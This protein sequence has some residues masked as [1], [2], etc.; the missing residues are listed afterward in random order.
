MTFATLLPLICLV[1]VPIIIIL[2]LMKPKGTRK[3]VPSVLLWK[4]TE[5]NER[6]TTF[7]KKL[8]KNILMFLEILAL[9]CLTFAA[10]SPMVKRGMKGSN[11][12]SIIVI[13]TS[14]SMQFKDKNGTTRFSQAIQDAKDYVETS[15]GDIS[16]VTCGASNEVLANGS[17][18]KGKL[19]RILSNIQVTDTAGDISKSEGLLESLK[20][21]EIII[22]TDGDGASRL[23]EMSQKMSVDI[24]VYGDVTS[25]V[26]I[27]QMSMK[28]NDAGTY[29]VAIGY[30]T[31]GEGSHKFDISLYDADGS[32][33]EVRTVD[34]EGN[35]GSTVLMM[36]KS[37]KGDYVKAELSGID[38][39][40]L[41]RDNTA[42][43]IKSVS[44]EVQAYMV[45]V[46]N[47]YFEKAYTA[48]TGNTM[49]KITNDADIPAGENVL[50]IYDR[51]DLVT[52]N[53]P[54]IV[55]GYSDKD[56]EKV[57]G[58]IVTVRTGD[59]IG[60]MNDY[61]FGAS[62]L[63]VL[64]CP[65]WAS[66]L[67]VINAGSEDEKVV[68][69]YG[70]NE[71]VRKV[72]LGFDI[73][74]TEYPLMAEFPIFVAEA[75]TY[76]TDDSLVHS[77]YIQ[78]GEGLS[79][80]PS[81]GKDTVFEAVDSND[82]YSLRKAGLNRLT[83]NAVGEKNSS[84][85]EY[86]VVRYPISEGDGTISHESMSYVKE[87]EYGVRLGSLTRI[88][89]IIALILLILDWII[90][91]TRQVRKNKIEIIIR[92]VLVILVLMSIFGVNLFGRKNKTV[93]IFL[94]DM[95]DSNAS[96]LAEEEEYIREEVKKLPR[97][98]S[99]GVVAFGR[100]ATTDQFVTDDVQ[101][102]GVASTPD[103]SA[104]DIEGAVDYAVALVPEDSLGRMVILTDG[105][106]TVG[107]IN[108]TLNKLKDNDI[109]ICAKLY[110][111]ENV[112]DVYLE[113]VDMPEKLEV[114]DAYSI[115][116]T[117]YSSYE[118]DA[119]LKLWDSSELLDEMNVHL[120]RGENT[121]VLNEVAGDEAIEERKVTIEA[122]GDTITENNSMVAAA[123]V[124]APGKVLIISGARED[125]SG[126]DS[127][128]KN[129]NVDATVVSCI[130]APD[131]I[132][133]LLNYK[134]IILDNCHVKDLPQGFI[135]VIETYVKDYGGGVI[136]TGG[137]ESYAPGGYEDTPLE[138]ILPVDME[139]KGLDEAPSLAM[140]M[141]IDC[142][143]SMSSGG[144][145]NGGRSK[146]DVA[147]DAA[148]EAVDNL[149]PK[150]Y[151]GVV[152]FSDT[153]TWRVPLT[154]VDDKE[155]IKEEIEQIGIMGGTVIKPA[156]IDAAEELSDVDAGV[157]HILLL[158]DGEG[159][160]K[161]FS[162][163]VKLINDNYITMSTIAVGSDSDTT[164]LE[165][166]A[167][168]CNGRYYYSDSSSD[169]PKIFTEEIYLSGNTYYKN[170]DFELSVSN[171]K[172][173]SELYKDGIPNVTGYIATTTKNGA[174]EAISTDEDD[175][176][177]SNWQYGLGHTVAWMT[178][179][180]GTWNEGFASNQD[181]VEMWNRMMDY[182]AMESDI[183]Q[184]RV[185]VYKRRGKV[186]LS[187]LAADYSE[188]TSVVGVYTSPSGETQELSLEPGDPGVYTASFEPSEMGVYSI[189]VRRME[190]EDIAASTTSIE[191]IQFSDEYRKDISNTN[192]TSF[193]ETNG[194]MLSDG[195]NLY[196][197]LKAEN[198][199][200]KDITIWVIILSI[201]ILL[202][203]IVVRRFNLGRRIFK[204]FS[205]KDGTPKAVNT[206]QM[207][208]QPLQQQ[209]V[210]EQQIQ[211]QQIQEQ[212]I[213]EQKAQGQK[214]QQQK[215]QQEAESEGMSGLDTKALLQ[216]KK[217][218]NL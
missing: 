88:C 165:E 123:V 26:G 213:Q 33:I 96:S 208:G 179:A 195:D 57:S 166:L 124:N 133:G 85:S 156:V 99:Y 162:D 153:F 69:Y 155:A 31:K 54:G 131:D 66:P 172:L 164:L 209:G 90:Y 154:K 151:V 34:A 92:T 130:N 72:V 191:T 217:N 42:Y 140:V 202:I 127:I 171:N 41:D 201:I 87:A 23:E 190:G 135:D 49:L 198:R 70:E 176:L 3:V 21:E 71:G 139:P 15:G 36:N 29:D 111:T 193:V 173:V 40:G 24:K 174:R 84:K 168:D 200:K 59:L 91:I 121:F 5:K 67:M 169:V 145:Q 117:V 98:Q 102:V 178:T 215:V 211:G 214:V 56:S 62:D 68:A 35:A 32:L 218:R 79:L 14:G 18:D 20:K 48:I 119:K 94:V 60:D 136:C 109:E 177:L 9:I 216:K 182:A 28:Q 163:A 50:A 77:K 206:Q 205:K 122:D 159:E 52:G 47:T 199:K 142:S 112:S 64:E 80:S 43:A 89:L 17:H 78:A 116:V 175:P 103:G 132:S 189:S 101:F 147:V 152:T 108:N 83:A 115:K 186:E 161:D 51:A 196:T 144:D 141:V 194:R 207:Y 6:S 149:G 180:S 53:Y 25:N 38:S 11:K 1:G 105:C 110:E 126:L 157:R 150:D 128:L 44:D 212:Q 63:S 118:V 97:G 45:G 183:G 82:D 16:I 55:E 187:Y 100:N 46:G 76:I 113:M 73:R 185:S 120:I 19:K 160:T 74:N 7:S 204:K 192:F 27:S 143:G 197:R 146:M 210:Q 203:D 134:T 167:E 114:G 39:D 158:T 13:D 137:R 188:N 37:V 4:N 184:D 181:Y 129:T 81:V 86:F 61:T 138:Q 58:A 125:S 107:D 93:T 30:H 75:V 95:S 10:M 106:E 2:Y 104:T 148:L 170:G 22:F 8:I 12:S 65:E